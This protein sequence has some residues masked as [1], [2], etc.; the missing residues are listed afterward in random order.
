MDFSQYS[1]GNSKSL[2]HATLMKG[3]TF[4]H[5]IGKR[6]MV[7]FNP[8]GQVTRPNEVKCKSYIRMLACTKVLIDVVKWN[9]VAKVTKE[10][11]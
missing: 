3:V 4:M 10:N 2:K 8:K 6:M 9:K 11:I 1:R 5:C 7:E